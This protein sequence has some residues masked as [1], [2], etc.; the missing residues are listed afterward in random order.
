MVGAGECPPP[1]A[2]LATAVGRAVARAG[3]VLVCGGL[4]GVMQAAARGAR[5]AGGLTIGVLPGPSHRDANPFVDVAI[6]TDLGHARNA[7]VVRSSHALIALPGEYGTLSEV[8]LALKVG[9]P[10]VGLKAWTHL[11]GV[12]S[13]EAPEEAVARALERAQR[14]HARPR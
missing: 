5:E 1:V 9:I 3:A 4:G 6:V 2:E 11:E 7:V 13:A 10:V 14:A 12:V 8:A